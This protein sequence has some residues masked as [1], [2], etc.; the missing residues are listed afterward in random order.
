MDAEMK[1]VVRDILKTMEDLKRYIDNLY[2][3]D[4]DYD[5]NDYAH[6][7]KDPKINAKIEDAL[8]RMKLLYGK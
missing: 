8:E 7:E 5:G 6:L 1:M 3:D 4:T 2:V